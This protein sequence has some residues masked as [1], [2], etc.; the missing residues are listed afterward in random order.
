MVTRTYD[1]L[2]RVLT[3]TR[4][5]QGLT[6]ELEPG[7]TFAKLVIDNSQGTVD[8]VVRLAVGNGRL[9]DARLSASASLSLSKANTLKT[10]ADVSLSGLGQ[11]LAADITRRHAIIQSLA[12]NPVDFRIGD[13]NVGSG[14]GHILAPG[15]TI[16]IEGSV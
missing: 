8:L 11:I 5:P 13:N 9:Q 14:R 15:E 3:E 7:E 10:V 4:S 16:I 1:L 6:V 2:D 12:T